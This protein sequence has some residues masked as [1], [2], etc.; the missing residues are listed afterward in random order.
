M[1]LFFTSVVLYLGV[2][3]LMTV[4]NEYCSFSLTTVLNI[5]YN[6]MVSSNHKNTSTKF[7]DVRYNVINIV[8]RLD[9]NDSQ[10]S[11]RTLS[12]LCGRLLTYHKHDMHRMPQASA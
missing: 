11:I 7:P 8:D 1:S 6:F 9:H 4:P 10:C 3:M 2:L 12:F 5:C